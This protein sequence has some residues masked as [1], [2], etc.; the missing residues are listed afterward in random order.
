MWVLPVR[1]SSQHLDGEVTAP[2][3]THT[4]ARGSRVDPGAGLLQYWMLPPFSPPPSFPGKVQLPR[5]QGIPHLSRQ[6]RPQE[7]LLPNCRAIPVL[8]LKRELF[9]GG[10]ACELFS[11]CIQLGKLCFPT[12]VCPGG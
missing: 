3:R 9:S 2:S 10:W 12:G 7:E 5:A 8:K 11:N 4:E 1:E 6:G